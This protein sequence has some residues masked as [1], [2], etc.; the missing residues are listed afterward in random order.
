MQIRVVLKQ[1]NREVITIGPGVSVSD[2]VAKLVQENIGSLP[3]VD[4]DGR[5]V[6]I[7][8]ERDLLRGLHNQGKDFCHSKLEEVMIRDPITCRPEDSVHDAVGKMSEH[9]IGQLPVMDEGGK[10]IGLVSVGDLVRV[11]HE[12]AEEENRQLLNYVQGGV[13]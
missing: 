13:F 4:A 8:T 11:L 9:Q 12:K 5:I 2:A 3:I 7:F 10:A 1:K 6:G